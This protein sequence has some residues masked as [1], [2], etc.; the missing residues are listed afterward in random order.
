MYCTDSGA[1]TDA[2]FLSTHNVFRHNFEGQHAKEKREKNY[3]KKE[4]KK[5]PFVFTEPCI[6]R[7]T[8]SLSGE[9]EYVV[10]GEVRRYCYI[11]YGQQEIC[12]TSDYYYSRNNGIIR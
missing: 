11:S 6:D 1:A 4:R 9:V 7:R 8:S 10:V 5:R 3:E 2:I 12:P